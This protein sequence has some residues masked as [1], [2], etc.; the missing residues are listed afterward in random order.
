VPFLVR[1][2]RKLGRKPRKVAT[3]INAPDIMPTLLGLCGAPVPDGV[4]GRDYSRVIAGGPAPRG[5]TSAF[6]NL[7]VSFTEARRHGFAEY[8]GLRSERHTYV[9]SIRGPWLLYDNQRDPHQ[10]R[11]LC[12]KPEH[13]ETQSRLDRALD[14]RLK[15]LKDDFLP[16]AEYLK[17]DGL[18]HY[19]EAN[20]PIGAHRSPWGDWEPTLK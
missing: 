16:G 11:N 12:G 19:R 8:R 13:K 3:P 2:P 14:A 18:T 6:I 20:V 15:E 9:R 5:D 17:R 1:W 4:E 7:P 10:M